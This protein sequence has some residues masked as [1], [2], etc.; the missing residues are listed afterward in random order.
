MFFVE[1]MQYQMVI[2]QYFYFEC[3]GEFPSESNV[4]L[5]FTGEFTLLPG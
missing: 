4:S 2:G 1:E 5:L 3:N